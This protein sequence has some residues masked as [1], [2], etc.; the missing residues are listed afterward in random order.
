M[1]T[2]VFGLFL[3]ICVGFVAAPQG[4][5]QDRSGLDIF[6]G[7]ANLQAEGLPD[8]NSSAAFF[9]ADFFQR[10]TSLHG[11]NVSATGFPSDFFGLTGDFS[12]NRKGR[13]NTLANG[14]DSFHTDVYYFMAGPSFSIRNSSRVE[15]FMR[16][17]AG[18]AHTRYE[19]SSSRNIATG[20]TNTSSFDVG[21][22]DFAA[23]AGAGLDVRINDNFKIRIFQ[24]DWAPVFLRN[25]SINVLGSNGVITPQALEGKRQDNFRFSAGIVF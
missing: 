12:F 16:I 19:V 23:A 22:T 1:K 14:E 2:K 5:A 17:L 24:A 4:S 20:G 18:G 6:A 9:D 10:R 7:Y 11:F 3:A 21:A 25:R 15:P 8:P 13:R